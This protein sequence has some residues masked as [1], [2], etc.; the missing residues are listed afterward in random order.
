MEL[1]QIEHFLS[2]VRAGS[3]TG[4]AQRVHIVQSAL[5]ASIRKLEA[6]LGTQ[7]FER[8]TRRVVL[9]EAGRAFLPSAHRILAEVVS[10][11]GA[12]SAVTGLSR[13]QV[14]IGTIQ[15]LSVLDLPMSL[16]QFRTRYPGVRIHVRDGR[17]PDLAAAVGS[18]ELDLSFLAADQPLPDELHSFARWTQYLVLLCP[19]GHRLA[20]RRRVRLAELDDEP[21]VDFQG[22]GIQAM[23]A[24][25]FAAADL[26]HHRVCEA[27]HM[28]LLVELVAAGLGITIV[29][30]PVA[31]K[32]GLPFARLEQ[33][34]FSRA[35][36]L[37]G[38]SPELTNPAAR[39]LLDHLLVQGAN[40]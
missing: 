14:A 20:P 38:R 28:P 34:G 23:V 7:L 29:P 16:G 30:E 17:V 18:G 19:P 40:P 13:G 3:F 11:R 36:H 5:S 24:R 8:T 21:F 35:I 39:A 12:V 32:S 26:R 27:T 4:A 1:R 15:T 2:V 33:P 37:A 10:G 6:E 22:S 31:E 25:L 9:T